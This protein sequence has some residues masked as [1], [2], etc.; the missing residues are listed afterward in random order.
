MLLRKVILDLRS[1]SGVKRSLHDINKTFANVSSYGTT[2]QYLLRLLTRYMSRHYFNPML[3][4]LQETP[5]KRSYPDD[6]PITYVSPRQRRYVAWL[7]DG[8]PHERTNNIVKA[9]SYRIK[10][11]RGKLSV[12]INNDIP[13][14]AYVVGNI[15]LGLSTRSI[16]RYTKPMQ[17][18]H[19][20]TGWK[21]A[22]E[23]VR[24][25]VTKAQE[26]SS[27]VIQRWMSKRVV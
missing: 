19:K 13:E 15:G 5:P 2:S 3:R 25:Y 8:E 16:K 11:R 23:I 12:E 1:A 14:S 7:L 21:P 18:F 22:H 17:P 9:W 10:Q 27:S 6:Y 26:E 4:E 24:K 20:K